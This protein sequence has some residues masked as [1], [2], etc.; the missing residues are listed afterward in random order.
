VGRIAATAFAP[1]VVFAWVYL[2]GFGSLLGFS[3]FLYLLRVSTPQKV[4]TSA[5][6]NPLVAVLLGWMIL[7]ESITPR[8]VVAGLVILG[9][10]VLIRGQGSGIGDQEV[11]DQRSGVREP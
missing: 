10:V 1:K 6:V 5:F 3:A 7:G 4:S 8:T 11:R 9:A 2:V